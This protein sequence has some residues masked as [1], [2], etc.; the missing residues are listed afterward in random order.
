M[1]VPENESCDI[2]I[3]KL[4]DFSLPLNLIE[5]EHE[6][7][8]VTA[9]IR[10]LSQLDDEGLF[11]V[12]KVSR[13]EGNFA[14]ELK[15]HAGPNIRRGGGHELI[16]IDKIKKKGALSWC[17]D[18]GA[19][20]TGFWVEG[21]K[22]APDVSTL[23]NRFTNEPIGPE[24]TDFIGEPDSVVAIPLCASNENVIG[25]LSVQFT[26][27]KAISQ[28][29]VDVLH[30]ISVEIARIMRKAS[31]TLSYTRNSTDAVEGFLDDILDLELSPELLVEKRAIGF[32]SR[33]FEQDFNEI[34]SRMEDYFAEHDVELST[35]NPD[36]PGG[37]VVNDLL[38][39]IKTS[40][41][42][43]ADITGS[44]P[45]VMIEVGALIS[46]D[47]D[48]FLFKRHEDSEATPFIVSGHYAH[49]YRVLKDGD[50]EIKH[51]QENKF[52]PFEEAMREMLRNIQFP[53]TKA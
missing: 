12:Y 3:K 10:K 1:S 8:I 53:T 16:F 33:P 6:R 40:L 51:P 7:R 36:R 13:I 20:N 43:I 48:I 29:F 26:N 2:L 44:N 31:E 18:N 37:I 49:T 30:E 17:L 34:G 14:L 47:R 25:V 39:Q 50:I 11:R 38:K 19:K 46:S 42:G 21:I 24:Y 22:A 4:H 35:Y 41:F 32:F 45:N 15:A 23:K 5:A 27:E 9:V 52:R 28:K